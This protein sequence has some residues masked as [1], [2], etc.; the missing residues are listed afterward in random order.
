MSNVKFE[1]FWWSEKEPHYPKPLHSNI[2]IENKSLIIERLMSVQSKAS[3]QH[4]RGFSR[5]RCCKERNGSVT[6]YYKGWSWPEGL[7]HYVDKHNI[8][9]T[10]EFLMQ[11][12]KI[13]R[14]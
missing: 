8:T 1:G 13:D 5:C 10:N 12:L 14:S 6:Y 2:E 9:L 7:L 11:V 3:K 4:Y